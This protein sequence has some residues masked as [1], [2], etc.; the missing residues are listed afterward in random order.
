MECCS[1][2]RVPISQKAPAVE[3]IASHLTWE[4]HI[5]QK[6]SVFHEKATY[7]QRVQRPTRPHFPEALSI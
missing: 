2:G 3:A 4:D 5:S 1:F 6:R 7:A